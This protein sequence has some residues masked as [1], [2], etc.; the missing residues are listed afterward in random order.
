[1]TCK[2]SKK[3]A[4]DDEPLSDY[5]KE[6]AALSF[7]RI[8][9]LFEIENPWADPNYILTLTLGIS[10]HS[11]LR[12]SL[13]VAYEHGMFQVLGLQL[14]ASLNFKHMD[15][16]REKDFAFN[17]FLQIEVDGITGILVVD[18][19]DKNKDKFERDCLA[20]YNNKGNWLSKNN[21]DGSIGQVELQF[22]RKEG[23]WAN[24]LR[25]YILSWRVL[26]ET[27]NANDIVNGVSI[28]ERRRNQGHLC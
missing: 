1:M 3:T 22:N 10:R 7:A 8:K 15:L 13:F 16:F 9:R 19:Y 2:V 18:G 4:V 21:V 12:D 5:I 28:K 25:L 20:I 27:D 23:K 24:A 14:G 26:Y 6:H 17:N 11:R